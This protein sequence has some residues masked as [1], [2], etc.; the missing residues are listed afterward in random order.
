M[1]DTFESVTAKEAAEEGAVEET[2]EEEDEAPFKVTPPPAPVEEEAGVVVVGETAAEVPPPPPPALLAL[3]TLFEGTTF[4]G[5][6]FLLE[7]L[8][9]DLLE[10]AELLLPVEMAE[11][12]CFSLLRPLSLLR[13][14]T[15]LDFLPTAVPMLSRLGVALTLFSEGCFPPP[16]LPPPLLFPLLLLPAVEPS[17]PA[18]VVEVGAV[19]FVLRVFSAFFANLFAFQTQTPQRRTRKRRAPPASPPTNRAKLVAP[20]PPPPPPVH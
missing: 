4:S 9:E 15:L 2:E 6:P 19:L 13:P 10:G 17:A 1:D 14:P 20:V 12:L 18:P 11:R 16:P 3:L 7:D 8:L 5:D